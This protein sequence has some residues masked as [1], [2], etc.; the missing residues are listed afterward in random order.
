M[1][2]AGLESRMVWLANLSPC[3]CSRLW[4][5]CFCPHATA[6]TWGHRVPA[7]AVQVANTQSE[8]PAL[9][10]SFTPS[11]LF[12]INITYH[13]N[14][15][16]NHGSILLQISTPHMLADCVCV[17]FSHENGIRKR[18]LLHVDFVTYVTDIHGTYVPG[19]WQVCW[20]WGYEPGMTPA[21]T[22]VLPSHH[23]T[24]L[25]CSCHTTHRETAGKWQH[26]VELPLKNHSKGHTSKEDTF[27]LPWN[28]SCMLFNH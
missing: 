21:P 4:G 18:F 10:P 25:C 14:T 20:V 1:C 8:S 16:W 22:C 26:K 3:P 9:N 12:Y 15:W 24:T 7:L 28:H 19:K 13:Y 17:N 2:G 27:S 23:W 5:R 6:S 11:V